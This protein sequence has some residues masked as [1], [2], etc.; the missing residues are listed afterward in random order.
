MPG[1]RFPQTKLRRRSEATGNSFRSEDID[2]FPLNSNGLM[3]E[4]PDQ[5]RLRRRKG[6]GKFTKTE[7]AEVAVLEDRAFRSHGKAHACLDATQYAL[8]RPNFKNFRIGLS[9]G[10]KP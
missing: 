8:K 5:V 1:S 6:R 2:Q 3:V 9:I 10:P 7:F 4:P